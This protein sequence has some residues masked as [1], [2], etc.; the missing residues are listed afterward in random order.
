MKQFVEKYKHAWVFSYL[1]LYLVWFFY[2]EN[3]KGIP[4][5]NIHT[6]LDNLIPFNELF[7]IPYFLWFS[8]VAITVLFLFFTS[9]DDFYKLCGFLFI[10]MT[11]CLIIYTV[12]PNCQNLR[13]HRFAR[14]NFMVDMVK[15]LYTF[16]TST[17]VCP[18]I[19][20]FNSIGVHIAIA[21]SNLL[22]KNRLI[23]AFSFVLASLICMST[24]FLKQ[25]S[26]VDGLCAIIL[27][28][29]MYVLV[30]HIDYVNLWQKIQNRKKFAWEKR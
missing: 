26:V 15:R 7:V 27:S 30:Y 17:N 13:P 11:I 3:R 25:H 24:V 16:D 10:G 2:L 19:H 8:Y 21:N 28:C 12:W 14:D 9:K 4:M 20:V 1:A 22:K 23:Q 29:V 5:T 18:S 6:G